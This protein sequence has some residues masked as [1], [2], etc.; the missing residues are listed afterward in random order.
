[1][2]DSFWMVKGDGPS[3]FVHHDRAEW[4]PTAAKAGEK[5]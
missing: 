3:S 1:M 5:Q 4:R 2:D